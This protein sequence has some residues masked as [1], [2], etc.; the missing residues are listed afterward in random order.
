MGSRSTIKDLEGQVYETFLLGNEYL[1]DRKLKLN[2][3][4]READIIIREYN[5]VIEYDGWHHR[6]RYDKDKK[7]TEELWDA[8]WNVIRVREEP[9]PQITPVDIS[10]SRYNTKKKMKCMVDDVLCRIQEIVKVKLDGLDEYLAQTDLL[11]A[12][13]S[14]SYYKRLPGRLKMTRRSRGVG[15]SG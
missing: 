5:L 8:G 9:L 1:E 3:R 7:K 4:S 13:A 11:T 15:D 6:D 14:E 12:A 10:V 2:G